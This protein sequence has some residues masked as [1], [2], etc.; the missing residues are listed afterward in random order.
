MSDKYTDASAYGAGGEHLG[1]IGEW[2]HVPYGETVRRMRKF[3]EGELRK[4][5][6]ILAAIDR[7]D[8]KVWHQLGPWAMK[9]RREVAQP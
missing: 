9:N 7:G 5:E 8:V 4:A 6:A 1:G 3:Y 2:G